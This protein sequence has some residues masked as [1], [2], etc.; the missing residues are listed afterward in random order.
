MAAESSRQALAGTDSTG[1]SRRNQGKMTR[2]CA[3]I[4]GLQYQEPNEQ[5]RMRGKSIERARRRLG[6]SKSS[7][8][9]ILGADPS[10]VYRW[11]HAKSPSID[12]FHEKLLAI[13]VNIAALPRASDLGMELEKASED[14]PLRGLYLLLGMAFNDWSR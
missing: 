10:T 7:L 5:E 8:G 4:K 12:P 11:E 1:E 3:T 9:R 14:D 6:L 2:N 13:V